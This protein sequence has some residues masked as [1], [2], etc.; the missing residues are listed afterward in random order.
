MDNNRK[1][2]THIGKELENL[3]SAL[4]NSKFRKQKKISIDSEIKK[5]SL[6][7]KKGNFA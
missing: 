5:A 4:Q 6:K 3:T 7:D 2:L 1:K